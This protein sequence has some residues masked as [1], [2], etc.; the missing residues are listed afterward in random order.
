MNAE[1]NKKRKRR[2][3]TWLRVVGLSA[4]C[5]CYLGLL[6]GGMAVFNHFY[7]KW[8]EFHDIEFDLGLWQSGSRDKIYSPTAL[9]IDAPRIKMCRDFIANQPWQGKTKDELKKWLGKPDNFPFRNGWDFNYW[10]GLQRGPM[11]MDSA[12]LCFRFDNSGKAVE[13]KLMQD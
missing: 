8:E 9:K 12:W 3:I 7:V 1:N 5:I 2:R 6:L 11:K 10:V 4:I 13:A